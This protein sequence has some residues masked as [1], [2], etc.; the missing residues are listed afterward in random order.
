MGQAR[1]MQGSQGLSRWLEHLGSF[2]CCKRPQRE[3]LRQVFIGVFHHH[4]EEPRSVDDAASAVK[5]ANHV[6]MGKLAVCCPTSEL[7]F[8]VGTG[9]RNYFDR[10][11]QR[12]SGWIVRKKYGAVVRASQPLPQG[13]LFIDQTAFPLLPNFRRSTHRRTAHRSDGPDLTDLT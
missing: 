1:A 6:G 5:Q 13:E 12:S 9:G 10:G 7:N 11:L 4:V 3:D 8:I 2:R